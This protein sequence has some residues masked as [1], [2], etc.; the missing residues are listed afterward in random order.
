MTGIRRPVRVLVLGFNGFLGRSIGHYALLSGHTVYGLSRSPQPGSDS[1]VICVPGDRT[2]GS[3]VKRITREQKIDVVV[4]V[5]PME[6]ETTQPLLNSLDGEIQQFVMISSAD[7]YANYELLHRRL[8]GEANR[9]AV[10]ESSALRSTR[11]PYRGQTLRTS[12]DPDRYLD[13]YDK[14]PIEAS[15][16]EL[17]SPWTILRLPMVYGPGDKQRRF[18]WAIAPMLAGNHELTLPTGWA[19]WQTTYG[20]IDNVGASIAATLGNEKAFDQVFNIAEEKQFPQIEW[21]RKFAAVIGW[22]GNIVLTDDSNDPFQ[23]Q[24]AGLDLNVPLKI[25]GSKLRSVLG[26]SNWIEETAALEKTV[27]SEAELL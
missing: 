15:V 16:R 27:A 9:H 17:S 3:Q 25:D 8:I 2:N 19:N 23:R 1:D 13:D 22:A 7:V 14:I 5:I 6:S 12:D 11:Y 10:D 24:L 26:I 21:A 18:R 4:D 20:F